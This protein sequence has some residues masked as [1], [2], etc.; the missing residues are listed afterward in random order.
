MKIRIIVVFILIIVSFM[1]GAFVSQYV[2][3]KKEKPIVREP[4]TPEE[5]RLT[6]TPPLAPRLP[7]EKIMQIR[8]MK[9]MVT[10]KIEKITDDIYLARGFSLGNVQMIITDQGLVIID[11]TENKEAADKILKEFRKITDK[12]IR[13]LIYTH[14]HLDHVQ[15]ASVFTK[16]RPEIIATHDLVKLMKKDFVELKEFH[17]RS[18][19]NQAGLSALEFSR[20]LPRESPVNLV[21]TKDEPIWPTI[22]FDKEY[23]FTLGG[24]RFELYHTAGETPDH[25]MVWLPKERALFCGDLY[26]MSFPNLST[27][28]L[29]PRTVKEWY[30]SLDRVIDLKP[31]FLIPGH[32]AAIIG[33]IQIREV[34]TNYSDAIKY[35]F[36]KTIQFINEGK[37]VDEAV[38]LVKLPDKLSKL[39]YLHEVYGRVDWSV[40]GIYQGIVGWYDGKGTKLNPLPSSIYARELVVL[41]GGADKI[42]SRAIEIQKLG[43]HQLVC[44]LCDIVIT[45]NPNDKLAHSIKA[46]SLEYIGYTCENLNM[47]GFYRSAASLERIATGIRP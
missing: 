14:G 37:T 10:P 28:M 44:E 15:G 7:V 29:E 5:S 2:S 13:Y 39:N 32:T 31:Q 22:A 3:F 17:C 35:V 21:C 43:E 41:A 8:A 40:R 25:L 47:F 12:P 11:S 36:G 18:R 23:K 45:A 38:Q 34:L 6:Y 30:E 27:P 16:D 1:L 33:E 20:K 4:S 42:L 9:E 19:L 26:Y 24:K 46:S